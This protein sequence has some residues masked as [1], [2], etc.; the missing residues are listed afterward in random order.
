MRSQEPSEKAYVRKGRTEQDS[1]EPHG[2]EIQAGR[3]SRFGLE[4]RSRGFCI[5]GERDPD[6]AS[7]SRFAPTVTTSNLQ[8]MI[9]AAVNKGYK[10]VVGG[11]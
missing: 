9:Q 6:A 11:T 1:A 10:G 3:S 2:E 8:V 5:R 4:R 7:L